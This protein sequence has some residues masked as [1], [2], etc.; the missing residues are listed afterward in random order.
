MPEKALKI[1]ENDLLYSKRNLD[2]TVTITMTTA[3]NTTNENIT[4]I[5]T[6]F[7]NQLKNDYVYKIPLKYICD[8]GLVN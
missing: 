8:L 4:D 2:F 7:Q 1:I 3:P 5:I 6:K